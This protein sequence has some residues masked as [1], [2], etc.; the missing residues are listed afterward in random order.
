MICLSYVGTEG[1]NGGPH[2]RVISSV[3][4]VHAAHVLGFEGDEPQLGPGSP[5]KPLCGQM[6]R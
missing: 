1:A 2:V 5:V 6:H 4:F 3:P